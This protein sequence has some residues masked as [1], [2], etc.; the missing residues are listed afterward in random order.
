[1][2]LSVFIRVHRWLAFIMRHLEDTAT[3]G[4]SPNMVVHNN[5]NGNGEENKRGQTYGERP[6]NIENSI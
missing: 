4:P 3:L 1:M 2:Y 6:A 5:T